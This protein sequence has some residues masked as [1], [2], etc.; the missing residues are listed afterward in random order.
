MI[1]IL[2]PVFNECSRLRK[3]PEPVLVQAFIADFIV[4][5]LGIAVLLWLA[6]FLKISTG[7]KFL[8]LLM[9]VFPCPQILM[10]IGRVNNKLFSY[11]F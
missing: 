6:G 4:Q 9:S 2:P 10:N 1:V 8:K 11:F 3:I 7:S 5:A